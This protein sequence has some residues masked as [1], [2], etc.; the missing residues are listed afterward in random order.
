MTRELVW[1]GFMTLDGKVDSPGGTAEGH[2]GGGWV[3]DT[4]QSYNW[5]YVGS[6]GVGLGAVAIMLTFRPTR[7][8]PQDAR[9]QPA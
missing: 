1:T 5:L 9:P 7:A 6:F 2:R 8:A 3:F 4:F